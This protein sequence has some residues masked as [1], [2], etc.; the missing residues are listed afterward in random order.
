[1][2]HYDGGLDEFRIYD[3]ALAA[4]DVKSLFDLEKAGK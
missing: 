4:A 1:M 2:K 3:K